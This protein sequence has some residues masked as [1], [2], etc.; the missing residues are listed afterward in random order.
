MVL[1]FPRRKRAARY[2][3]MEKA[4]LGGIIPRLAFLVSDGRIRF[5]YWFEHPDGI[6]ARSRHQSRVLVG[7]RVF[8]R[9][10]Q[11]VGGLLGMFCRFRICFVGCGNRTHSR[12][13]AGFRY[14]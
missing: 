2:A 8:S 4:N 6:F 7:F 3:P 1:N 9:V 14:E 10:L 11:I 13:P 12:R 5:T